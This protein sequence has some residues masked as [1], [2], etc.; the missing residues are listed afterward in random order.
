[1][2]R[3]LDAGTIAAL[4]AAH[5]QARRTVTPIDPVTRAHPDMTLDDAYAIQRAWIEV[6]VDA[7]AVVRGHKVG[8]TS[9]AMQVAMK[10]D[11]PDFGVLLD[12]MF[13]DA[14]ATVRA[15]D[16]IDPKIEVELAFVLGATLDGGDITAADVLAATDH[17]T[18]ALELIDAR[19][20]RV[21]PDDGRP[22]TVRDTISDNAADAGIVIG[23]VPIAPS[24]A[25]DG[26]LR[27]VGAI[28][29]RNGAVEETGL[30]AGVLDDPVEGVV[31]LA[32]RLHGLGVELEAGET[33]LAGSFTRP[34]D[35]RAGDHFEVDVGVHGMIELTVT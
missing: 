28:C 24:F 18:P 11:E 6:R 10:I 31:W 20:Y 33:V 26:A 5:E 4:A 30:A 3:T 25:H 23:G 16:Y 15:A 32:N 35:C 29:K 14:G 17:I 12:D 1:M 8:L 27:W 22:R 21:H 7:G 13:I 19:S 2:A 34:L 9:R